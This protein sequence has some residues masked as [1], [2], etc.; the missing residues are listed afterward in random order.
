MRKDPDIFENAFTFDSEKTFTAED[1]LGFLDIQYSQRQDRRMRERSAVA[2]L[3][4]FLNELE[5]KLAL[6]VNFSKHGKGE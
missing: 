1:F 5:G 3:V 2:D 6:L 4:N